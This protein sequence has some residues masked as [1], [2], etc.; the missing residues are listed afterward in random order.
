MQVRGNVLSIPYDSLNV[1]F[2]G[3]CTSPGFTSTSDKAL[4]DNVETLKI[5]DCT[6]ILNAVDAMQYTRN[7]R[8]EQRVGFIAQDLQSA[9]T[10]HFEHIV[11]TTEHHTRDDQ[12]ETIEKRELLTVDYSRLVTI[13]WTC[14]KDTNRRMSQ[15]ENTILQMQQTAS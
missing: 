13:L 11:G 1:T 4:K 6:A 7:D 9:C 10:G 8:N 2:T 3:T 5:K 15:L 14:L 12:G